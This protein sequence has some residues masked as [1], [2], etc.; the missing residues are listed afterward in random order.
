M[1]VGNSS[2]QSVKLTG[3]RMRAARA[4]WLGMAVFQ[5]GAMELQSLVGHIVYGLALGVVFH[6][7]AQGVRS[8]TSRA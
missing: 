7:A 8:V 5:V 1:S 3:F 4:V 6:S 2:L